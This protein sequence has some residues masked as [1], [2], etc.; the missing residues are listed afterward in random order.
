LKYLSNFFQPQRV[1][2][3]DPGY[4]DVSYDINPWMTGNISCVN[5]ELAQQQWLEY[6]DALSQHVT[7][8]KL[9]AEPGLPD[10]VF[11]ANAGFVWEDQ[12]IL[13]R[14]SHAERQA[15]ESVFAAWFARENYKITELAWYFEGQGD[16]L[17]DSESRFWM[18]TGFRSVPEAAAEIEKVLGSEVQ[19]LELVDP[20]WYHLDTA[21]CPLPTGELVW[22]PGAFSPA[23][24]ALINKHFS[25]QIQVSVSDAEKFVCNSVVTG[26]TV[27]MPSSGAVAEQLSAL[28]YTAR[29]LDFT[30]FQ[31]AGGAARCLVLN[32]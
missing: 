2:V 28:G 27:F 20:R 30:E 10:L 18:G 14:F 6:T 4:Y 8:V 15:E 32:L 16:L 13:S 21:F 19:V 3:C 17:V 25:R 29:I 22:Y 12:V 26:S 9:P 31:L 1:L 24:R 11:T 5:T 7:V 23:S